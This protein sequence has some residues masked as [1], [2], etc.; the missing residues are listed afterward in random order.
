MVIL[1]VLLMLS[2]ILIVTTLF[3]GV[4]VPRLTVELA[5]G[6]GIGLVAFA[7]AIVVS[8][9][10]QAPAARPP[11][12]ARESWTMPQ[13]ALLTRPT[14]TFPVRLAMWILRIYLVV[15]VLLLVV[16]AVQL[17]N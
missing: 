3:P 12:A 2:G 5:I 17:A 7:I 10:R 1:G 6:L 11:T 8:N 15:A 9:R 13:S 16:K 14:L 4:N